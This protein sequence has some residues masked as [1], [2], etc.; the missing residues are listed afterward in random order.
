MVLLLINQKQKRIRG[1]YSAATMVMISRFMHLPTLD[2][3]NVLLIL[4]PYDVYRL[5]L[6][7]LTE[8]G[9]VNR[10][11]NKNVHSLSAW[12]LLTAA[13]RNSKSTY[14]QWFSCPNLLHDILAF[15]SNLSFLCFRCQ[16]VIKLCPLESPTAQVCFH[17]LFVVWKIAFDQGN[18]VVRKN[19]FAFIMFY[20][21]LIFRI[22]W[23][24]G[25][26]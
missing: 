21:V 16:K 2:V 24:S 10:T 25:W 20:Y 11:G 13:H 23:S 5:Y 6:L 26:G 22:V 17:W 9:L 1:S 15:W 4:A 14:R 12:P 8:W 18:S 3:K 19:A 7:K